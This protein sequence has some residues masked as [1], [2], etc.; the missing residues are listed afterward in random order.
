[1]AT[2]LV[3]YLAVFCVSVAAVKAD[4]DR[5]DVLFEPAAK[6][7]DGSSSTADSTDSWGYEDRTVVSGR[8]FEYRLARNGVGSVSKVRFQSLHCCAIIVGDR[9]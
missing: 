9:I 5:A 7:S 1:M 8:L 3:A 2:R 4:V 6:D